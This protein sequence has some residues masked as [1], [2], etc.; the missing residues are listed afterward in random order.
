MIIDNLGTHELAASPL[1]F[2]IPTI[3]TNIL[4]KKLQ[5]FHNWQ[6]YL[7]SS[8][9]IY[10]IKG[11]TI[12]FKV[13]EPFQKNALFQRPILQCILLLCKNLNRTRKGL[14][15]YYLPYLSGTENPS[16]AFMDHIKVKIHPRQSPL[17]PKHYQFCDFDGPF[18]RTLS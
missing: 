17:V 18:H 1:K 5:F 14:K 9:V 15:W 13:I 7:S 4:A 2:T 10:R 16:M 6:I 8:I 12:R 3:F 11:C